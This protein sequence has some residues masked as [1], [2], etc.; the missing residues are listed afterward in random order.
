MANAVFGVMMPQAVK[1]GLRGERVPRAEIFVRF[2]RPR[3]YEI[4]LA[5]RA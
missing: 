5:I 4:C 2:F 3:I 1:F